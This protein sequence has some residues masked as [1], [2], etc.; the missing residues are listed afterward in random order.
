M[1]DI[2]IPHYGLTPGITAKAIRCLETIREHSRDYRIIWIDNGTPEAEYARILPVL[3]TVPQLPVRNRVNQGFVKAI[4]QGT[5]LSNA[6]LVVLMNN[7]C[8]AVHGWLE[9]LRGPFEEDST[10]G[11]SGPLTTTQE[12]W[13]GRAAEGPGWAMLPPGRMLAFFCVMLSRKCLD[14]VGLH[15]EDFVPYGGLGSDDAYCALAEKR[16]FRLALVNSLRIPHHHRTSFRALHDA[17]AIAGMQAEA[18]DLFREK[19]RAM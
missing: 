3:A 2:V 7:D 12:S 14:A 17:P 8:E 13:Q 10:V 9:K 18:L 6:P 5:C 15:D 4:N 11:L 19:R 16:G 1:Y